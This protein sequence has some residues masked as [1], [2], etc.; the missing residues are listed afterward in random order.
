MKR[1]EKINKKICRECGNL[2]ELL[3]FPKW[4]KAKVCYTCREDKARADEEEKK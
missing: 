4:G 2:K 3:M 1:K